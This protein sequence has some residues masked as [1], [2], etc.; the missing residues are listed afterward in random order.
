M[1]R[2]ERRKII[3]RSS[4]IAVGGNAILSLLKIII[5][6]IS[7]S[8]AVLADGIDSATDI[9]TSLITLL[10]ARFLN[11]KPNIKYPYGYDKADTI[12]STL[13][14]FVIFFA[15]AQLA[16]S[17]FSRIL[18]GEERELPS[19]IAIYITAVSIVGKIL[20]ARI[21]FRDGKKVQSAMILANARN[22]Q[23]D[24]VTSFSVLL[25]LV[26]TYILDLAVLD[27]ITAFIV[28]FY[29]MYSATRIF[30]RTS[31][32]LMDGVDDP[33]VYQQIFKAIARVGGVYKPHNIKVRKLAHRFLIAVDIEVDGN[34][35]VKEAHELSHRVDDEIRGEVA[36]VYDIIIHIEPYGISGPDKRYG[37][38][39]KDVG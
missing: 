11:R 6:I 8:L 18:S 30:L 34:M 10:T 12:A 4:W 33:K 5:G 19:M 16:I 9:V 31:L 3:I 28:S 21:Q 35:S 23:N 15:G 7:G 38:S 13:L 17:T 2:E 29:I 20:L 37:V 14:A 26:F 27:T 24:V 22:M 25:G 1:N 32:E 36:N 39:E